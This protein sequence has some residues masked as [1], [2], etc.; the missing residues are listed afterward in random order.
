MASIGLKKGANVTGLAPR[1]E[2]EYKVQSSGVD[3]MGIV[4][5]STNGKDDMFTAG[6]MMTQQQASLH[7]PDS[8]GF[9]FQYG[10]AA[11]EALQEESKVADLPPSKMSFS[12]RASSFFKGSG[13]SS[14]SAPRLTSENPQI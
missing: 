10:D 5:D 3:G 8:M 7:A 13:A 14:E 9:D 4:A 12:Q 1:Q 11:Y 6:K 2:Y